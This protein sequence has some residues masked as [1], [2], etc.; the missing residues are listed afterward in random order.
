M[1]PA[2]PHPLRCETCSKYKEGKYADTCENIPFPDHMDSAER[3]YIKDWIEEHGCASH[4]SAREQQIEQ[5]IKELERRRD[6]TGSYETAR[7]YSKAIA[8]LQEGWK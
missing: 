8:L 4:S 7:V 5:A 1:T 6:E 3:Q 2:Q